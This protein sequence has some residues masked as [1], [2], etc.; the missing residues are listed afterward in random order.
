MNRVLMLA[1]A[2]AA[3]AMLTED[4]NAGGFLRSRNG[5]GCSQP[6]PQ[7][8][9]SCGNPTILQGTPSVVMPATPTTAPGTT[10]PVAPNGHQHHSSTQTD[11]T[12]LAVSTEKS[13]SSCCGKGGSCCS[14]VKAVS[15]E[16]KSVGKVTDKADAKEVKLEGTMVC[17]KCG[18]KEEG[19]RRCT[20]ALQVKDGEKIVTYYLNDKGNGEDYHEGLCGGGKKEGVKVTGTVD[21]KDGKKWVKATKVEEKK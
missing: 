9:A 21:E 14:K 18:L 7:S 16:A 20:N 17:A 6:K 13:V 8:V 4:A 11:S 10:V 12:K 15:D 5:C 3:I 2:V 19:V 1:C